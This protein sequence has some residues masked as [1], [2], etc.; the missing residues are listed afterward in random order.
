[1]QPIDKKQLDA[2]EDVQAALNVAKTR[3]DIINWEALLDRML[4]VKVHLQDLIAENES[5]RKGG[6]P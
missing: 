4:G 3:P 1:M 2:I 6:K 5:L